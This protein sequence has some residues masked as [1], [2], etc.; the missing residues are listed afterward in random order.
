VTDL[1]DRMRDEGLSPPQQMVRLLVGFTDQIDSASSTAGEL[2][3]RLNV[4]ARFL[5]GVHH[6]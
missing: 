4:D 1:D 5:K 6:V 2:A 3:Q